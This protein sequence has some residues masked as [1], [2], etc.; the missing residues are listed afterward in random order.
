MKSLS[1]D[2]WRETGTILHMHEIWHGQV[3]DRVVS[4]EMCRLDVWV[5]ERDRAMLISVGHG[6]TPGIGSLVR[7]EAIKGDEIQL[8]PI[9]ARDWPRGFSPVIPIGSDAAVSSPSFA[10]TTAEWESGSEVVGG[11]VSESDAGASRRM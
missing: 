7:G 3:I 4:A 6:A 1:V 2:G 9:T 10:L 11:V 8:R 5:Y